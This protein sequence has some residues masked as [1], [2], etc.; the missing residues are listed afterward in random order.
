M[1]N[2]VNKLMTT[3]ISYF[4]KKGGVGKST[5]AYNFAG[6]LSNSGKRVLIIDGDHQNS[7]SQVILSSDVVESMPKR[8]TVATLFDN[9]ADPELTDII[10]ETSDPNIYLAVAN[11]TLQPYAHPVPREQGELQFVFRE[12]VE[13]IRGKVDYIIFDTPPDCANLMSWN[14][15]MASDYVVSVLGMEPMSVQSIAGTN[16]KI[17]EAIEHGNSR[18]KLLGYAIN[19]FNKKTTLHKGYEEQTRQVYGTQVFNTCIT[20]AVAVPEAQQ[21][22]Q[23][24]YQYSPKS[25]TAKQSTAQFDELLQRINYSVARRAA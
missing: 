24:I 11:D 25:K 15:L 5:T 21:L 17:Q 10:H 16:R 8:N 6:Y 9:S 3:T 13:E 12:F 23:H 19:M 22:Q 1:T 18:L 20:E 2:S 4:A 14:C 7:V